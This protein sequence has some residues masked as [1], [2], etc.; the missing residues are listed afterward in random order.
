[1]IGPIRQEARMSAA[2]ASPESL[3]D[4]NLAINFTVSSSES[5]ATRLG[6]IWSGS[7]PPV[8][9]LL[10]SACKPSQEVEDRAARSWDFKKSP[11]LRNE[12]TS[13]SDMN[14]PD[15]PERADLNRRKTELN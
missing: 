14:R 10:I 4:A 12:A 13:R 8:T 15:N 3:K 11:F 2:T 7:T 5:P 9:S 1:M 6:R